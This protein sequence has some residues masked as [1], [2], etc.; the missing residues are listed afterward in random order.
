[1]R[2]SN[3]RKRGEA[4]LLVQSGRQLYSWNVEM[5]SLVGQNKVDSILGQKHDRWMRGGNQKNLL[6][7]KKGRGEKEKFRRSAVFSSLPQRPQER[8]RG[9][10]I[11]I[12]EGKELLLRGMYIGWDAAPKKNRKSSPR[13]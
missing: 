2:I 6:L 11:Y 1:V 3:E 9:D 7:S 10:N 8:M 12:R 13:G 4:T 5:D